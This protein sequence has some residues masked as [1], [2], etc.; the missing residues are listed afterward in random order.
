MRKKVLISILAAMIV[1]E[2]CGT[3]ENTQ[4]KETATDASIGATTVEVKPSENTNEV[5]KE[6]FEVVAVNKKLSKDDIQKYIDSFNNVLNGNAFMITSGNTKLGVTKDNTVSYAELYDK[7][8]AVIY[9]NYSSPNGY[10]LAIEEDGAQKVYK[11]E[12]PVN[13]DVIISNNGEIDPKSVKFIGTTT[14]NNTEYEIV[15][16]SIQYAEDKSVDDNVQY[17]EEDDGSSKIRFFHNNGE[18]ADT[19]VQ[20][21]EGDNL[22]KIRLL[23]K[24]GEIVAYTYTID[25]NLVEELAFVTLWDAKMP[26]VFEKVDKE[27]TFNDIQEKMMKTLENSNYFSIDN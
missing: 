22:S 11:A 1:L 19:S 16:A 23:Y 3:D 6:T 24:D 17:T 12:Y 26:E 20:Y 13:E 25:T 4:K 2:G 21:A 14:I 8:G 18:I 7:D 15:D 9:T 5:K 27:L 10:Y